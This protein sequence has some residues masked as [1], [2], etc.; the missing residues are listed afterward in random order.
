MMEAGIELIRWYGV[1]VFTDHLGDHP[2]GANLQD[3]LQ[4]EYEAGRRDPYRHMAPLIHLIG[5]KS[6]H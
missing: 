5:T 3:I 4:L 2:P 6:S 1:R